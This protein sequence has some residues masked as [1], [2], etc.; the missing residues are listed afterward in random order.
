M[1][2]K[3]L[4]EGWVEKPLKEIIDFVIGGDWGKDEAEDES[5]VAVSCIRGSEIKNWTKQKGLSATIRYIKDSSLEK[6]KLKIGD[7]LIEISG[8]GPEQPVGRVVYIDEEAIKNNEELPKICANF[9][10][11]IRISPNLKQKFIFY[12]LQHFYITGEV[13]QYQGGS[14]NLRNLKFKDYSL[15]PIPLPPLS[16]QKRIVAKLDVAFEHIEV[17]KSKLDRIPVLLKQF[18]QTVLTHAVTGK[19]TEDWRK[20]VGLGAWETKKMED[21]C[22][23]IS[24]GDHQAPP[25]VKNGIPFLVISN[26]SKGHFDFD[27]VTRFVPEHYYNSIKE[28]RIPRNGDVLYTVTG[29]YGIPLLVNFDKQ[30]CF[31][32]HIAILKPDDSKISPYYLT[33][34]L[35][36]DLIKRQADAVATGTAQLTVSLRGI[37]GFEEKIPSLGEQLAIVQQLTALFSIADNIENQY[38]TLKAKT[39]KLPQALLAKAFKGELVAQLATDGNANGLLYAVDQLPKLLQVAEEQAI[40][41]KRNR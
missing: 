34:L 2:E 4:A 23:S 19:L 11:L 5:Y 7:I 15:I 30:F 36:S 17:L 39:D 25:Q 35:K 37:K 14:N 3:E 1:M 32:R 20:I 16:E 33:Y 10:R 38:K 41:K 22:F 6:R 12:Y 9:L 26:V 29:S 28:T 24:D 8:G 40:Y 18:K 21:L 13:V 31:Q 27:S